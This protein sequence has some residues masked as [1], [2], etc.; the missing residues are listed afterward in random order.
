MVD[1]HQF[2]ILFHYEPRLSKTA[3]FD[4]LTR[5]GVK[6]LMEHGNMGARDILVQMHRAEIPMLEFAGA[7]EFLKILVEARDLFGPL[8]FELEET[9]DF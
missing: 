8:F 6:K 9:L 5:F 2:Q 1:P 7:A 3:L 4:R